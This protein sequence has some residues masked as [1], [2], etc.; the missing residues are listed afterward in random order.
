MSS[1]PVFGLR[2]LA[3][4]VVLA[5]VMMLVTI[6]LN[7]S[8]TPDVGQS[9]GFPLVF[10]TYPGFVNVPHVWAYYPLNAVADFLTWFIAAGIVVYLVSKLKKGKS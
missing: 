4:T 6:T 3:L 2:F 8:G 10:G 9:I 5:L 7:S 1:S